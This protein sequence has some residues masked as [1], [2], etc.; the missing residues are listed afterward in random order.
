MIAAET[1]SDFGDWLSPMLVK[2]LRQGMRSKVFMA[3]FYLTQLL[4]ILCVIFN[5]TAA[6]NSGVPGEMLGFLSG[7]FWF[8]ISVPLLFVMPIRGF[9]ALH[10]EMKTGTLELVFLTRLSAWRIAAGKW[11]AIMVQ[12]LLLVCAVLPYVLLR[13]FLGGVDI[14]EDLQNLLFLL[15]AS[16]ALTGIT[17]AMS[18]YESKLLRALFIF[19]L[20]FGFQFLVGLIFSYVAGSA[21]GGGSGSSLASW[22]V[23]VG[24]TI[25]LPAF[26]ML[27]LEIAASRIAPPSEN[28]ALR[29]R[30]LGLFFL[31][32]APVF[33]L[34][35]IDAKVAYVAALF[36]LT[37]VVI[38]ALAEPMVMAKSIYHFFFRLGAA[39]RALSLFFTPGWVSAAWYVALVAA[40]AGSLLAIQGRFNDGNQTLGYLS[41]LG[42]LIFP[43]ALIRLFK[44]TTKHFLGFY[45]ALQFFLSAV[46][47]L[48]AMMS[49][50]SEQPLSI[51]LCPVPNSVFLLNLVEQIKPAQTA[52]FLI[53]TALTTT[54]CLGVL[55][56]RTITPLRDIRAA[57]AQPSPPDA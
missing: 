51:W 47:L 28:H 37:V 32:S 42:A 2:E 22:P 5:L 39:G 33:V 20:I 53:V 54:A 17:I 31:F 44:P 15:L 19:G 46:T 48:V 7:L 34:I 38:D 24:I 49:G 25:F 56:A 52:E 11:T 10:G 36:F 9:G 16:A 43:A 35:G 27:C 6:S 3:A 14:I 8:M 57:L 29:K 23:Y 1:R 13:Y 18:P 50:I 4:M 55:L 41:L 26:L 12:T 21:R 45:I 30:L 40:L